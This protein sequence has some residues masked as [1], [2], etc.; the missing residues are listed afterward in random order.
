MRKQEEN[1]D[2]ANHDNRSLTPMA[3]QFAS[4]EMGTI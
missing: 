2:A 3:K 4:D 1:D